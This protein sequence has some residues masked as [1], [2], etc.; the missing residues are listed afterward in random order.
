[1]SHKRKEID[2]V[3]KKLQNT[4]KELD[5]LKAE[6][7]KQIN[8]GI[9][10]AK[11]FHFSNRDKENLVHNFHETPHKTEAR[12]TLRNVSDVR[13]T[14]ISRKDIPRLQPSVENGTTN[15]NT[16][17][18][19][20]Y[21]QKCTYDREKVRDFIK[22]QKEKRKE[23]AELTCK[24]T[25]TDT[26]VKKQKLKEL[27]L[28]SLQL[29][30][31]NVER[32]RKR[33]KS[34]ENNQQTEI[35][36][37]KKNSD[38]RNNCQV[39]SHIPDLIITNVVDNK[40]AQKTESK[41]SR[42]IK[43]ICRKD[44]EEAI[45]IKQNVAA[46]KI[47]S[48]FRAYMQRQRYKKMKENKQTT[49]ITK[50]TVETQTETKNK[51]VPDWLN[52]S[53]LSDPNNFISAVKRKLNLAVKSS[54][55]LRIKTP[56]HSFGINTVVKTPSQEL[57]QKTKDELKEV[58]QKSSKQ[59]NYNLWEMISQ[60]RSS[61]GIKSTEK[62]HQISESLH[63]KAVHSDTDTS[64]NI[65]NI[66]THSIKSR[67]DVSFDTDYPT[68]SDFSEAKLNVEQ[69]KHYRVQRK[70]RQE[71][72]EKRKEETNSSSS[73]LIKENTVNLLE[74]FPDKPSL[75][76]EEPNKNTMKQDEDKAVISKTVS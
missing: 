73:N 50:T 59:N 56:E 44:I 61:D 72:V 25:I 69:L 58:I 9:N 14:H 62:S 12:I 7:Q 46:T 65:P 53:T 52:S 47:Q 63:S 8:S 39:V 57:F 2:E 43:E 30:K 15:S 60:I 42:K 55:D 29:V 40:T 18:S 37:Q 16:S 74:Y 71:N 70:K 27:H 34:R 5:H 32:N 68:D 33:S 26:E 76:D 45:Q 24:K 67:K 64:K 23:T 36:A 4:K 13:N 3:T 10:S 6:L 28:K 17:K 38:V 75:P 66:D 35:V 54:P 11:Q 20:E 41:T 31:K 19:P 49:P 1:M 21:N 48:Y 22:K 51:V